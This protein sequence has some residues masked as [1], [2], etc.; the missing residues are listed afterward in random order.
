LWICDVNASGATTAT[1]ALRVLKRTV[2][3]D[4]ELLCGDISSIRIWL[5]DSPRL[6]ALQLEIDYGDAPGRIQGT[7][8][9]ASCMA[10]A[11][12]ATIVFNN[13]GNG[14]LGLSML[15][16]EGV[17]GPGFLAECDFIADANVVPDDFA[18]AVLDA[19]KPNG[20][21]VLVPPDVA[22]VPY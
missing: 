10:L 13:S 17:R 11:A 18:I 3:L 5:A 21:E 22:I 6:G 4:V 1:D 16:L 12:N 9:N 15:S 7:G 14:I 2:G 8:L 19:V 20:Q